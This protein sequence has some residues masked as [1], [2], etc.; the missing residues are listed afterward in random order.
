MLQMQRLKLSAEKR[1]T[2][3]RGK[4]KQEDSRLCLVKSIL[5]KGLSSHNL[6]L[7]M[8]CDKLKQ[9]IAEIQANTNILD[10]EQNSES[11][12]AYTS[13]SGNQRPDS[14][15]FSSESKMKRAASRTTS[16]FNSDS[17]RTDKIKFSICK[18]ED[19]QSLSVGPFSDRKRLVKRNKIK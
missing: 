9:K 3:V 4:N 12:F 14:S 15:Y 1:Q 18:L 2:F 10:L 11:S 5:E 17:F 6:K 8:E 16:Q 19:M 7:L 13:N